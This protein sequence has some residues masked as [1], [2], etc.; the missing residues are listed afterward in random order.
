[1]IFKYFMVARVLIPFAG[2]PGGSVPAILRHYL[3]LQSSGFICRDCTRSR[4][5]VVFRGSEHRYPFL[6]LPLGICHADI[7]LDWESREVLP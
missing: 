3:R 7:G 2:P 6:A 5:F 1:M 4:G